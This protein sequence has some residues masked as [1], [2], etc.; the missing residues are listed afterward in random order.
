MSYYYKG[1]EV[2][3]RL[4]IFKRWLFKLVRF[5]FISYVPIIIDVYCSKINEPDL[6]I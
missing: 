4:L 5:E 6:P 2:K 3:S 1:E